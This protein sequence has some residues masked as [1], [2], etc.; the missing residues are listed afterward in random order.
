[1]EAS[2]ATL[3]T[4]DGRPVLR[5]ERYLAHPPEKV[6]K[7]VTDPAEMEYWFPASIHTE[8]R[9]GAPMKF[10]FAGHNPDVT[11]GYDEG[12]V[13]EF[14]PPRV[15][16]FR[17]TD[18][19]LRFEVIP[20]GAGSRLL[21]SHALSGTGT[22]GDRQSSARNA[23]GWDVCLAILVTR[24]DQ[25]TQ[26]LEGAWSFERAEGYVE[27]FGLG[28]GECRA[29]DHGYLLRF[30]RD[31]PQSV[32]A[33]WAQLCDGTAVSVGASPPPWLVHDAVS[34]GSLTKV[35]PPHLLEYEVLHDDDAVGVVRFE[36]RHQ[37]PLGCRLVV[38][39]T[40][41]EALAELRAP[42]LAAWQVRLELLFAALHGQSRPWPAERAAELERA[43]ATRLG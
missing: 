42:A 5:F 20:D 24:L 34:A 21:F 9:V 40:L 22:W 11:S 14:D 28:E 4:D 7:A 36:L 18:S 19:V 30:E 6:W 2:W 25:S 15:Y 26:T 32:D 10:S 38:T 3:D 12:E 35:D 17:W 37:E 27:L 41:P 33:V 39:Q 16:A 31:L 13:L 1:M 8:L 23:A 29:V 43:Y